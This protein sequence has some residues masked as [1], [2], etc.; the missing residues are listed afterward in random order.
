MAGLSKYALCGVDD[1][2]GILGYE[3]EDE[4]REDDIIRAINALS[5]AIPRR[6]QRE[7][8]RTA[9]EDAQTRYTLI[10]SGD[11]RRGFVRVGD[12]RSVPSEVKLWTPD[13]DDSFT[14]DA[15][16]DLWMMP[17]VPERGFPFEYVK[18]K[19]S[20]ANQPQVGWWLSVKANWGFPE[21]PDDIHLV[22]VNASALWVLNDTAKLTELA[23]Q[24]GRQIRLEAL[25]S[26]EFV[27][28]VEDYRLYRVA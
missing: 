9:V 17:D 14:Y 24:Q 19:A 26:D 16:T 27:Q 13:R 3:D 1:V 15:E 11:I 2:K 20:A 22:A 4:D 12:I 8:A 10:D 7:F 5:W 6:A 21:I 23:R 18:I 25:M 28:T